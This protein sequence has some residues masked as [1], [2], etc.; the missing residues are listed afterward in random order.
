LF[1]GKSLE[2]RKQCQGPKNHF[3]LLLILLTAFCRKISAFYVISYISNDIFQFEFFVGA[4]S[5]TFS[6]PDITILSSELNPVAP[7]HFGQKYFGTE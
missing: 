1:E 3:R 4:N 7:V 5:I 2:D 6:H